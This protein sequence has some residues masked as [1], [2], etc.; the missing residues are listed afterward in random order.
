MDSTTAKKNYD[1]AHYAVGVAT[2]AYI[3]TVQVSVLV[4]RTSPDVED[5]KERLD[6]AR[7][8]YDQMRDAYLAFTPGHEPDEP[9]T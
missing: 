6:R 7:Q 3:D 9:S 8:E 1:A 2:R 4:G 5:A